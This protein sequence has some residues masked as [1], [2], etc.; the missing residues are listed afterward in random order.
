MNAV[1][2]YLMKN[3][4]RAMF[5]LTGKSVPAYDF[6]KKHGFSEQENSAAFAKRL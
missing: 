1:E 5:L 2:E 4:I 6:Y 3:D